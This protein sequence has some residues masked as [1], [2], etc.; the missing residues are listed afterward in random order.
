MRKEELLK[1]LES[2]LTEEQGRKNKLYL[3]VGQQA[4]CRLTGV[5]KEGERTVY[6]VETDDNKVWE[7]PNNMVLNRLMNEQKPKVGDY[8]LIRFSETVN[9]KDDKTLKKYQLATMSAKEV[10][11]L[12]HVGEPANDLKSYVRGLFDSFGSMD[13]NELDRLVNKVRKFNVP[14]DEVVVSCGLAVKDGKVV[15]P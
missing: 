11:A 9:L 4:M 2:R 12:S 5:D 1:I 7:L 15:R 8:M 13:R 14:I 6:T 10:E 3:Q